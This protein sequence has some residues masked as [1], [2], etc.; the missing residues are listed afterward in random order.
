MTKRRLRSAVEIVSDIGALGFDLQ[1]YSDTEIASAVA[2][3][4]AVNPEMFAWITRQLGQPE[5]A[6]A[7]VPGSQTS[8]P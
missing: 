6:D 2:L 4:R 3:L 5:T 1:H 8:N 7:V